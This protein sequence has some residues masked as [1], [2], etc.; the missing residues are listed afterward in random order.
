MFGFITM[1]IDLFFRTQ[2]TCKYK[3]NLI[4]K[5]TCEFHTIFGGNS[6]RKITYRVFTLNIFVIYLKAAFSFQK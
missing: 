4:F 1:D 3:N 5:Y 2:I 6:V